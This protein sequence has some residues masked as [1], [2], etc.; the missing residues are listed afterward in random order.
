[1]AD[2]DMENGDHKKADWKEVAGGVAAGAAGGVISAKSIDWEKSVQEQLKH[3]VNKAVK[4]ELKWRSR[5]IELEP[6]VTLLHDT[7]E[8]GLKRAARYAELKAINEFKFSKAEAEQDMLKK[9][10]FYLKHA[11][12]KTQ[13][14]LG[15][16]IAASALAAGYAIHLYRNSDA[17]K[18]VK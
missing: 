7:T 12:P 4:A 17:G 6:N 11:E 9:A 5:P 10:V 13:I 15:A 2:K 8:E 3:S 1:M 16:I 18:Q 14:A